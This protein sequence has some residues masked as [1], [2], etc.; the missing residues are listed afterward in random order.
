MELKEQLAKQYFPIRES[1]SELPCISIND[2]A[3]EAQAAFLAGWEAKEK[4]EGKMEFTSKEVFEWF[5]SQRFQREQGE[6]EYLM[7]YELDL[8]KIINK[9]IQDNLH[10]INQVK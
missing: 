7:I 3:R 8:P 4:S 9:F 1:D 5:Q 6:Q 10:Q 2:I